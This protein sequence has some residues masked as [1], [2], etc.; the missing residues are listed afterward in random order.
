MQF[1]PG[2]ARRFALANPHDGP[3]AIEAAARYVKQ[4]VAQFGGRLDLVLAGYNAGEGAVDCYR[5]GRSLRTSTG[6]IINPRGIKTSGVPPYRETVSY[7]K[8]GLLVFTRV[9]SA[10]VFNPELITGVRPLQAPPMTI[11]LSDQRVIDNELHDLGGV[12]VTMLFS[13]VKQIGVGQ[14][15]GNQ[16]AVARNA[17]GVRTAAAEVETVFFDVHS[18]ARYLVSKGSIV[19]PIDSVES[20]ESS[21][22]GEVE[23]RRHV[24]AKSFYLGTGG[25]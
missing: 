17:D 10:G 19:K 9:T 3:A 12:P 25:N 24:V 5:I 7:V 2:T 14:S 21:S 6:K 22:A 13:G 20:F 16:V 15:F 8:R 1:M 4:L 11:A 23:V 18:G